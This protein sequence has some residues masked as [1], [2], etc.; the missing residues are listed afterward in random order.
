MIEIIK[1]NTQE[2]NYRD[3]IKTIDSSI[4]SYQRKIETL[5][6]KLEEGIIQD[7]LFSRRYSE[8][9]EQISALEKKRG[10]LRDSINSKESAIQNL[11]IS[12]DELCSFGYKWDDLDDQG[13]IMRLRSIIKEISATKEDLIIYTYID[14]V[15]NPSHTDRGS[16]LPPA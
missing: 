16:W 12:F 11:E 8:H 4:S 2:E 15:A 10:E 3:Q 7:E 9:Q 13:K 1:S 5:L 14:G 6:T